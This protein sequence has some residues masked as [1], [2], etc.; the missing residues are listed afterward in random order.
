[1]TKLVVNFN[2]QVQ[3]E[4]R[5][6]KARLHIGRRPSN[7]IVLDHLAV[8]GRHA[9]IDTTSEGSFI[10][11]LGSTN[12]TS[13]NGQPIKK[14]LLQDGDIIE[15]GKYRL[16]FKLEVDNYVPSQDDL[17]KV[18]KIKVLTGSN[19]GKEMTLS[20]PTVTLG[21]PGILVVSIKRDEN[22]RF[23]LN[24]VEGK[25]FPK[26]NSESLDARPRLLQSGDVIDLSGTKMEFVLAAN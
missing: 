25:A 4:V 7:D 17:S 26:V 1:M 12:G 13:V 18:G 3:R 16:Q 20:K 10:L 21:S 9:A 8:S 15:L 11:D 5:I 6:D 24:F 19:A 22:N 2:G 23:F 14:H